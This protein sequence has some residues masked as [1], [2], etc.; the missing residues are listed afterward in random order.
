MAVP[1]KAPSNFRLTRKNST[2]IAAYWNL[3]P[4]DSRNGIV[5]GFRLFYKKKGAAGSSEN[6]ITVDESVRTEVVSGLKK[7]TEYE[8]QALAFTSAGN[9]PRSQIK[10]ERTEED[11]KKSKI[12]I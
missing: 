6:E 5:K 9:G 8:F 12:I 1:S 11:G 7:Y 3:P 10:A 2:S 4:P